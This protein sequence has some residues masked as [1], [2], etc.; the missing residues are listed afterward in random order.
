MWVREGKGQ[1]LSNWSWLGISRVELSI[2]ASVRT[3]QP[4]KRVSLT[5][6]VLANKILVTA[7]RLGLWIRDKYHL[8]MKGTR[9]CKKKKTE[10]GGDESGEV[11]MSNI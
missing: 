1:K 7:Q 9:G 2:D 8:H 11:M 4:S 6:V 10:N 5:W 3:C